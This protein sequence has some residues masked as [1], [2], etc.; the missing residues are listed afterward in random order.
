MRGT[1]PWT[2][3]YLERNKPDGFEYDF[4][5]I[6]VPNDHQGKV[7]PMVTPRTS[8]YLALQNIKGKLGNLLSSG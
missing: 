3:A 2:I 7:T 6:P 1:G 5:P 4:A 8:P